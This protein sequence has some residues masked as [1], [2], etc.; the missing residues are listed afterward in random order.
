MQPLTVE[1][2]DDADGTVRLVLQ[3]ALDTT[4]GP[5]V[6]RA[7]DEAEA[8]GPP[9]LVLDFTGLDFMD[10][11]GL[12]ILLDADTRASAGDHELEIVLGQGEARR[13]VALADATERLTVADVREV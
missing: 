5:Q 13:V 4:T 3:G 11:T 7:L 6:E 1:R 12:Q 10:S 9:R 8:A 2:Q